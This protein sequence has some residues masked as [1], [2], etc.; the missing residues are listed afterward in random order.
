MTVQERPPTQNPSR[1]P[2]SWG[3]RWPYAGNSDDRTR[4]LLLAAYGEF[5]MAALTGTVCPALIARGTHQE[6]YLA[7]VGD[8]VSSLKGYAE[9]RCSL[10]LE[11]LERILLSCATQFGVDVI[12]IAGEPAADTTTTTGTPPPP[13]P[14]AGERQEQAE[15]ED[16]EPTC[17][18]PLVSPHWRS[19]VFPADGQ[20]FPRG[21]SGVF[22]ADGRGFPHDISWVVVSPPFR[23]WRRRVGWIRLR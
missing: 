7:D 23:W 10:E 1:T 22:P 8:C 17:Q 14:A 4:G 6:V 3:I 15:D 2:T 16:E 13:P 9:G 21:R 19:R 11:R 12:P 18:W 5:L 20:G